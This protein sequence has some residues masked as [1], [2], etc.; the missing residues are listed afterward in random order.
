MQAIIFVA[1]S[2]LKQSDV[3]IKGFIGF[4]VV[5]A[6]AWLYVKFFFPLFSFLFFSFISFLLGHLLAKVLC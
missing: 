5:V 1:V 3:L 2:L 6:V 4:V